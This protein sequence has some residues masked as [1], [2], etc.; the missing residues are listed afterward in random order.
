MQDI[1]ITIKLKMKVLDGG[2]SE[3]Q[4]R[5][6]WESWL[7]KKTMTP[8]YGQGYKVLFEHEGTVVGEEK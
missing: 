2:I 6:I 5:Q 1:E 8:V 7:Q 4:V 3:N